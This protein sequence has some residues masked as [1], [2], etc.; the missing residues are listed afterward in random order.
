ME[1]LF[2]RKMLKQEYWFLEVKQYLVFLLFITTNLT[3][4]N[5]CYIR[6]QNKFHTS[7]EAETVEINFMHLSL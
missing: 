4:Y 1:K 6:A 7:N 2:K 3:R 5:L